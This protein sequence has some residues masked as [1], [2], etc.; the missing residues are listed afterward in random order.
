M[1]LH[2]RDIRSVP[3]HLLPYPE[4]WQLQLLSQGP[5]GQSRATLN[6]NATCPHS[7]T[8]PLAAAPRTACPTGH[9]TPQGAKPQSSLWEGRAVQ[10]QGAAGLRAGGRCRR[11]A[12]R[13]CASTQQVRAPGISKHLRLHACSAQPQV[14]KRTLVD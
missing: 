3:L 11:S 7:R 2:S 4:K 9:A 10:G 6:L 5:P 1:T 12:T 8:A 14:H 13:R